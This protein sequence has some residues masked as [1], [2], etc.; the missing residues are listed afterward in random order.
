MYVRYDSYNDEFCV[1]DYY[2]DWLASFYYEF[3]A[4]YYLDYMCRS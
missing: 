2:G 3:D 1:Y 4:H